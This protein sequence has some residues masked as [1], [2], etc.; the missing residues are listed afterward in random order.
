MGVG[1]VVVVAV[2][3]GRKDGM[4]ERR[5]KRRLFARGSKWRWKGLTMRVGMDV[6]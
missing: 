6:R 5:K 3:G 2:V 4:K 1:V